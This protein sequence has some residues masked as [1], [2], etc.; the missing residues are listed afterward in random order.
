MRPAALGMCNLYAN[1]MPQEA[2]RRLFG[3]RDLLGNQPP[4]P[5]IYPDMAAPIVV[6]GAGEDGGLERQLV[7][8][9]WGWSKA[10]FGWV[11]NVR[12]LGGWPWREAMADPLQ[13][14]LVP[15]T[16][17]SEYHPTETTAK[18]HKAAAWFRLAGTDPDARAPFAFAGL[19]RLWRFHED[20]PRRKTDPGQGETP[21][22]AFLTC[23]PNG[24][25]GPIHPKAMPV[26]LDEDDYETWLTAPAAEAATLQRP[27]PDARLELAFV[28]AKEDAAP[29]SS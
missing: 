23:P 24:V 1:T 22:F 27:W 5:A 16:S 2:M 13:R 14:C 9:R 3:A 20:G 12:N 4:L 11:T 15:A 18:G 25:V 19:T 17:F 6:T 26:I 8:A 10:K 28:G 7:A 21:C 29:L